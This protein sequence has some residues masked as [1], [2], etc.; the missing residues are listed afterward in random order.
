MQTVESRFSIRLSPFA[1]PKIGSWNQRPR[2]FAFAEI[3]FAA[4]IHRGNPAL[5]S[6]VIFAPPCVLC[7]HSTPGTSRSSPPPAAPIT[8]TVAGK[9]PPFIPAA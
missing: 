3:P 8:P 6:A 7:G 2:T 5:P 1:C 4:R 9:G